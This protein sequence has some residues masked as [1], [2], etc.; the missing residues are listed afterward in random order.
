MEQYKR[1]PSWVT[2]LLRAREA[3]QLFI[4]AGIDKATAYISMHQ[5]DA[6]GV[7]RQILNMPGYI[8]KN[9]LGKT[10]EGDMKTPVGTFMFNLAFGLED[11]PG[12]AI[13]YHKVTDDDYWSG[14]IRDGYQYNRMVSIRDIPDLDRNFS[15]HLADYVQEYR[16]CLS[17][18][19]NADN[20]PGKGSAIFLHCFGS[21]PYTGGCVAVP[22]DKMIN[23]MRNVRP[24]CIV[25]ID[26]LKN[27]SPRTWDDLGLSDLN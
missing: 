17:I 8:G 3:E 19:Y 26:S 16:Y 13:G 5:K 24:D 18:S 10:V 21:N 23:V 25:V 14:D 4:V 12:C 27:I 9:G 1:S 20:T 11:D 2:E 15:E 6:E 22:E 7:W